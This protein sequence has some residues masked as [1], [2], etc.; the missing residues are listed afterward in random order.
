LLSEKMT[1]LAW[2]LV[3]SSM[4]GFVNVWGCPDT[5]MMAGKEE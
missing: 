2:F 3:I 5:P 4:M 1:G